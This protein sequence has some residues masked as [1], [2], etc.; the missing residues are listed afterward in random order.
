M[1]APALSDLC[2]DACHDRKLFKSERIGAEE[3]RVSLYF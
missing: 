1:V 2:G 3:K